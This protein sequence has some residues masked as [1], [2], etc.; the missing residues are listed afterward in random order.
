MSSDSVQEKLL[1]QSPAQHRTTRPFTPCS[2]TPGSQALQDLVEL[3]EEGMTLTQYGYTASAPAGDESGNIGVQSQKDI[4]LHS[5][6]YIVPCSLVKD[7]AVNELPSSGFVP[8]TNE[9]KTPKKSSVRISFNV[10]NFIQ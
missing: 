1:D 4:F 8:E 10:S 3:A 9:K 2:G 6:A 5:Q 7:N